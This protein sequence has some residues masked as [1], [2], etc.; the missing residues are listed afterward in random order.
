MTGAFPMY[1]SYQKKTER[2]IPLFV[3]EPD[4]QAG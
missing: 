4:P 1:R 3:L 2:R